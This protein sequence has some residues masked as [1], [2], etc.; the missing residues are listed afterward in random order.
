MK[1]T[2]INKISNNLYLIILD[3]G[4]T[5][6]ND[7]FGVWLYKGSVTYIVDV[8]PPVTSGKLINALDDLD[9]RELDYIL[10]THI[11][12]DHAGGTAE[13]SDRFKDTPII[14]HEAGIPH[15]VD[16]ARLQ[17]GTI[18]TLGDVG[19]AYGPVRPVPLN[20]FIRADQFSSETVK[21]VITPGHASHHV[22]FNTE[23]YLF[24]GEAGGVYLPSY[25]D[26]LRPGTPP[27]FFLETF[28][29]SIDDLIA[30][31]PGIICYGHLGTSDKPEELL[32]KHREQLFLWKKIISDEIKNQGGKNLV[33]SCM[34]RLL[35]EDTLLAGF[36][37]MDDDIKERERFFMRNSINGFEGYL[38]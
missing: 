15:L 16:P 13:I 32:K 26:Y 1:N 19:R 23:E 17:Q 25:N 20:R 4:I 2:Q 36:S 30:L 6:F 9:V 5:G 7:F 28:V 24:A 27:R 8:G 11:H 21:P 35:K 3:P 33:E 29:K 31:K 38:T 37:D 34:N 10:L 14:C 22:S 12:V 18:K